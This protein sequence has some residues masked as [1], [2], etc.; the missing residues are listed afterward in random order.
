MQSI[1]PPLSRHDHVRGEPDATV[2]VIVYGD[3]QCR[4][5]TSAEPV[6]A[7]VLRRSPGVRQTF[8]HFPLVAMHDMAK[9]AA[10]TAEFAASHGS[11]WP[12]HAALMARSGRLDI[13]LL[14]SLAGELG[15]PPEELR[16][17]LFNSTFAP[18]I[19]HDF[20]RGLLQGVEGTPTL[21]ING[22]RYIGPMTVGALGAAID[23][24]RGAVISSAKPVYARM[25][26]RTEW[27]A[28]GF[29]A[30]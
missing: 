29:A 4:Y 19:G 9:L 11:F 28:S 5:C 24:A 27:S 2:T 8:R 10:E 23:T 15:L 26:G 13:S 30:S 22:R 1:L 16:D 6:I 3:Y 7:E 14:L 25:A 20:A 17:D 21:F 18:K 12:M